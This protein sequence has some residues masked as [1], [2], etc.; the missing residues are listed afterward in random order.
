VQCSPNIQRQSDGGEN[1]HRHSDE[2]SP[3]RFGQWLR[4]I[5]RHRDNGISLIMSETKEIWKCFVD[6]TGLA[7]LAVCGMK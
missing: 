6:P 1:Q 3:S 5:G 2:H 7:Q 4:K